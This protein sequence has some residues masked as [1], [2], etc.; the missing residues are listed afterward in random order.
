MGLDTEKADLITS[1][2]EHFSNATIEEFITASEWSESDAICINLLYNSLSKNDRRYIEEKIG[3]LDTFRDSR[4]SI[5]YARELVLGWIVED[6]LINAV[7]EC[8]FPCESFGGDRLREFI[9]NSDNITGASDLSVEVAKGKEVLIE[10]TSDFTAYWKRN[11]VMDLR[12]DK[13]HNIL[14]QDG[15]ILG[16]DFQ[17]NEFCFFPHY[18]DICYLFRRTSLLEKARL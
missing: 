2:L 18:P 13:Y 10:V 14:E 1:F 12:N 11:G 8:G 3:H 16:I 7:N 4:S 17:H 9:S 15:Y 5:D 6:C